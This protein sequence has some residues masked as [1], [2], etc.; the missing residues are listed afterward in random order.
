MA[1]AIC[2][3]HGKIEAVWKE[4]TAKKDGKVYK[5]WSCPKN[6]K[7]Q[8][9]NWVRCKV[10]VANTPSGKFDQ[11]LDKAGAKNDQN[12]K[13]ELITRTAI[14]KSLL[15]RGDKWGIDAIKEAESVFL[16][17]TGRNQDLVRSMIKGSEQEVSQNLPKFQTDGTV[18]NDL[19]E[20]SLD[21]IPF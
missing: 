21:S 12:K 10:E 16:W 18:K 20:I 3:N 8:F 1:E 2:N 9:G 4:V 13:D 7:D 15:E 19:D 5:F 11:S 6:E 17:V 14:A